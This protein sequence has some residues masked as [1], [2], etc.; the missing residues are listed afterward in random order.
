M[1]VGF[2]WVWLFDYVFSGLEMCCYFVV[3]AAVFWLRWLMGACFGCFCLSVWFVF[4]CVCCCF[5]GFVGLFGVF[6]FVLLLWLLTGVVMD[7]WL[8]CLVGFRL[9]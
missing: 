3:V 9:R 8:D 2:R 1:F 6:D 5:T 7:C 4:D